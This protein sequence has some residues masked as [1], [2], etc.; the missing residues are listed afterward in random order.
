MVKK[1]RVNLVAAILMFL[2]CARELLIVTVALV[3]CVQEAADNDIW[4]FTIIAYLGL[5]FLIP[6]GLAAVG[7]GLLLR[8]RAV[9]FAGITAY[10]GLYL[11]QNIVCFGQVIPSSVAALFSNLLGLVLIV[12]ALLALFFSKVLRT[13]WGIAL[14][15]LLHAPFLLALFY[16]FYDSG[17][18]FLTMLRLPGYM[19]WYRVII[20][21]F[22]PAV[23][24]GMMLTGTWL[25]FARDGE[26]SDKTAENGYIHLDVHAALLAL[27]DVIWP[28]I[29]I[30]KTTKFL[31]NAKTGD[32][33]N[34]TKKLLLCLFVPFYLVYWVYQSAK[35]I[36]ILA[37]RK[38]RR[39]YI[40]GNCVALTIFFG[41][42]S[43][44]LMQREI[45]GISEKALSRKY[46]K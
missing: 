16:N 40:A 8:K 19:E 42:F 10:F 26:L 44:L 38:G 36:E 5:A 29:W 43:S 27:I 31:N 46:R 4:D 7:V 21:I 33:R 9:I 37:L 35:R 30:Y 3:E 23:L 22:S 6:L 11:A 32:Y 15:W 14:Y 18:P 12:V 2:G 20:A 41:M 45:N 17:V 13:G 34:P 1:S 28:A 39:I 25:I 24:F